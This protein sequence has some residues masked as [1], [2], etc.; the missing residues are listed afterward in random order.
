MQVTESCYG[1]TTLTKWADDVASKASA[2]LSRIGQGA[3]T[4]VQRGKPSQPNVYTIYAYNVD[5]GTKVASYEDPSITDNI[6]TGV[7]TTAGGLAIAGTETGVVQVLD[8]D[9]L[10]PLYTFNV[11]AELGAPFSTWEVDGKQY[12]GTVVGGDGQGNLQ[13]TAVGVVFGL[14]D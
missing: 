4:T 14:P 2:G 6:S 9:T 8:S 11:G 7:L 13:Q 12:I 10:K 5:D 1:A 3:G